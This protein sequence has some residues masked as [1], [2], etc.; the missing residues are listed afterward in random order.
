MRAFGI[1]V[2]GGVSSLRSIHYCR[3]AKDGDFRFLFVSALV[4][5]S[6][7]MSASMHENIPVPVRVPRDE[8]G[9]GRV[10]RNVPAVGA[11]GRIVAPT[12]SFQAGRGHRDARGPRRVPVVDVNIA[13]P[14]RVSRH[15]I[16]CPRPKRHVSAVGA[17]GGIP[18]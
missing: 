10:K 3:R 9:C 11:D 17:D 1:D 15:E 2:D 12:V 16:G 13:G 7:G 4:C 18:A 14:V 5:D 6:C 8:I